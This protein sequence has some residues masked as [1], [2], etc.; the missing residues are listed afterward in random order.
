MKF[1]ETVF[2]KLQRHPKRIVF[3]EGDE[4]RV[5]HAAA[6]MV[7]LK[8]AAPIL[9]GDRE[10]IR[11]VAAAE[12]V[13]LHRV[14]LLDPS[15]ASDLPVFC[16]RLTRFQRYRHLGPEETVSFL[17]NPNYFAAM[18]IQCGQADGLVGGVSRYAGAL[19]RPLSQLIKP[20]PDVPFISSCIVL[21]LKDKRFGED[22]VLFLADCG[23]IP[24]PSVQQ[25]AQIGVQTGKLCAQL[26]GA[27][28]R[29]AYLSFSTKGSFSHPS[30]EKMN[31]AAVLAR[32]LADSAEMNMEID[33][34]LQ[35]DT[36]LLPDLA[37]RKAPQSFVAGRANVLIFP[38]L[39]SSSIAA[40][41]V[42]HLAN[43]EV[44]GQI[45]IGLSKPCADISR[46][47][48][49]ETIVGSAAMVALQAVEY[50]KLYPIDSGE[51][52]G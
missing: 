10:E 25:L 45:L 9:L 3:P 2:S 38:D 21:S 49:V 5:I 51:E 6:E 14:L 50:R 46:G 1:I 47:A 24:E 34:E 27:R 33:G 35:A 43:A 11:R 52:E 19:L 41:L 15:Q 22:G 18:M 40:R 42:E 39:N 37:R 29:I 23:V 31:A 8:I 30:A 12:G 4:P 7:R 28:P 26:T 48:T 16:Q 36:A 20:L 32:Q 13:N 44:Y 17:S